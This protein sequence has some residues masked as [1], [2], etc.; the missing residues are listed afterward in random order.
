MQSCRTCRGLMW[1]IAC[2]EDPALIEKIFT[3]LDA[4]A[5]KPEPLM[6]PPCWAPPERGLLD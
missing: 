2:I 5:L 6:S 4:K 1:I 3:H